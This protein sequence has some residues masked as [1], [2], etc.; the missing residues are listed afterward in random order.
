MYRQTKLCVKIDDKITNFFNSNVGVMQGDN[1]SPTLFKIFLY[2][3]QNN[4]NNDC[5]PVQLNRYKLNCLLYADDL[6]LLSS[7]RNGMQTCLD[8]LSL[9]CKQRGLQINLEKTKCLTFN[10]L[11]RISTVKFQIDGKFIENVKHFTYLGI[12]V[13]A[14]GCFNEARNVIYNK[15]MKAYF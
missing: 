9:Y 5:D 4:L 10:S 6:V 12:T 1:L 8:K 3:F 15:G 11:G 2:D 13:S 14:S 7:T